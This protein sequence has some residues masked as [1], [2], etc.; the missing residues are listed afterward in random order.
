M[1][2]SVKDASG[3]TQTIKTNDDMAGAAGTPNANVLSI[4]GIGGGLSMAAH[5]PSLP[6]TNRS[7]TITTGGTAQT[8]AAANTA[9][10]G[11]RVMNLSSA[12]LW[13]ND[14]GGAATAAQPSIRIVSGAVYESPAF[15]ASTAAISILG[16]TTGQAFE[17]AEA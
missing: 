1:T 15:G 5:R 8:L 16:A 11:Y 14:K 7:G 13:L 6:Y 17:A 3:A 4:Q 10:R 9:R 2:L 12:D